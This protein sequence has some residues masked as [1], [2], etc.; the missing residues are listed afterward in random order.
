MLTRLLVRRF[1]LFEEIDIEL[2]R[3]VVFV[4]PN[5]SGKTSALQALALWEIGAKR[6]LEKRGAG[7]APPRRPGVTISRRELTSV[8]VNAANMLWRDLRTRAAKPSEQGSGTMNLLIEILVEGE[9]AQ[10]KWACGFE[11]DYANEESFYCRPMRTDS[12]ER[13]QVPAQVRTVDI[14]Y[15]PPM[16]GLASSEVRLE[17]GAI[18]VRLGEGRT[19]EVL[20]NLCYQVHEK[21]PERWQAIAQAMQQLFLIEL[22]E[23][24]YIPERGEIELYYRTPQKTRLEI[25]AAGRG[26]QQM[27]FVLTHMEAHSGS[28]ILI[29]EPDA[30]LEILRQREIYL[31]ISNFA[32]TTNSQIIAAS[33]SE[34]LLN[35]AADRDIVIAFLGKPHRI[36]DR[37][38]RQVLKALKD[39]GFVD[40]YQAEQAGWVLY[41]E[42][43]TDLAILQQFA[44]RLEHPACEHLR[45]AFVKYIGN[46]PVKAQDHFHGLREAIPHLKGFALFDRLEREL[47]RDDYLRM[48]MWRKREIENYLCTRETLLNFAEAE[49]RR[50]MNL[51][52]EGLPFAEE[53]RGLMEECLQEVL[54][55]LRTLNRPDPFGGDLKVSDEFLPPLFQK[56]YSRLDR[57]NTM[58]KSDFHL[59]AQYVPLE[60]I[61]DEVRLVLD[62]ILETALA[63]Q[64]SG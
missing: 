43:A 25:S 47:P 28:V 63:A 61:D 57:A 32:E 3:R 22:E 58:Q 35:E 51:P 15:L 30:H 18:N 20:R 44:E 39:I 11:F 55:A 50:A 38:G 59:L 53:W 54:D 29:D 4:G 56:F 27:L 40:Y 48:S 1:K 26:Q 45:R 10:G 42:G 6:W 16:S 23:P 13:M 36:D 2:G 7:P 52:A 5:N 31:L 17:P 46:Q 24:L 33:H 60:Q 9:D 34:V 49:A 21:K 41:L 37:G 8:P 62:Q 14:A 64:P 19:A 12:G